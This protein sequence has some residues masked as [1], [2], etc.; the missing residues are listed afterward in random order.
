MTR[1]G[2]ALA[3]AVAAALA[4]GACGLAPPEEPAATT[5]PPPPPPPPQAPGA[6]PPV[7][8]AG[9]R[10]VWADEFDGSSL[11]PTRWTAD[12]G[13][14]RDALDTP[15]AVSVG[16]GLLRIT[17]STEG[18]RHETGFVGT[19]GLFQAERGYFEARIRFSDAPGSWCAFWLNADTNGKP[20]G[21]PEHAGVEIDVAEHRVTDQSGWTALADM[22]AL[23]LN[24]DG[25][26]KDKKTN[27]L[28]TPIA[29]GAPV[30]G[31]WHTYGV[32]WTATGYAFYVDAVQ[33]WT[34][35]GP[36]SQRPEA[37]YL[38]CEVDDGSWAGDVPAG[39]YGPRSGSTT[40]MDVD[41]VRVWQAPP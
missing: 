41:W 14:R 22:V 28:V 31:A 35:D 38:T 34:V 7:P 25:Y 29:G 32:L 23:T 13:R 40:G 24:W 16:G 39:G 37:L 18:G 26:G 6:V 15:D 2:T 5:T 10:L 27:Q 17:T 33:L 20:V 9:Y 12:A 3:V 19:D 36:V 21:D 8:P 1:S 4:L 11:D 30:Q